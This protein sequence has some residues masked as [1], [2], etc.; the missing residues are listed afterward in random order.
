M[1]PDGNNGY[2]DLK[3]GAYR[4][5]L[6]NGLDI[7]IASLQDII[8]SKTAAGRAKDLATLPQLPAALKR[9]QRTHGPAGDSQ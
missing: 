1:R 3:H 4:Q 7:G 9:Q 2:E 6:A 5:P 8:R